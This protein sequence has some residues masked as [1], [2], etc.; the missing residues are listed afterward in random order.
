MADEL[1]KKAQDLFEGQI[2]FEG[3]RVAELITTILLSF[4]GLFAFVAGYIQ[5]NIYITLWVGLGGSVMTFLMVV[6]P[7]PIY[8]DAPEKW[9]PAGS[10]I[11]GA[12]I[13]VDG[14]KIN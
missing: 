14:K 5:Q 11:A 7:W 12:G 8:N 2:D 4:T 9:L 3:Q 10:S 13:E 1:L 6:P